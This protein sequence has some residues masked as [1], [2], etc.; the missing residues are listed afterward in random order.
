[1]QTK[2]VFFGTDEFAA[3]VLATLMATNQYAIIGVV[4]QPDRP[5]GRKQILE[6]T[7]V[8]VLAN[9]E[10]LPLFTPATLKPDSE[11]A[12]IPTADLYVVCVYGIIIPDAILKKATRGVLNIHPSMLP[13]YRG[14]SPV[15]SAILNGDKSIGVSIMLLDAEMDHGPILSQETF[16]LDADEIYQNVMDRVSKPA[17]TLLIKSMDAFLDGTLKPIA[18]NH[19]TATYCKIFS[20]DDG[21]IN[22]N[23]PA[24]SL[25]NQYRAL[26]LWPGIFTT[27]TNKRLKLLH[28][29]PSTVSAKPGEVVLSDKKIFVGSASGSIHI[30]ELQLEGGKPL[31]ATQFISGHR[32]FI[33]SILE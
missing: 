32:N 15:Q 2:I 30:H 14:P 12:L 16:P 27:Y 4:T 18:Q 21:K 8:K 28:V 11:Q 24:E 31:T 23:A 13:K 9:K 22:W 3:T 25:Y 29:S 5:A 20:R 33:G 1:M 7:P 10:N 6:P 26:A 19:A 17:A